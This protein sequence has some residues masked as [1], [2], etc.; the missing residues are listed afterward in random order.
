MKTIFIILLTAITVS[1]LTVHTLAQTHTIDGEYIKEWLVLG[2]FFPDDLEVDFLAGVEGEMNVHPK[3]GDKVATPEGET[4]T[5]GRY[6]ADEKSLNLTNTVGDCEHAT[7]YA[8]CEIVSAKAQ[9][10]GVSSLSGDNWRD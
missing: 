5:W 3:E 9:K 6:L 4:L 1:V 7:A 8:F 10:I 2:P